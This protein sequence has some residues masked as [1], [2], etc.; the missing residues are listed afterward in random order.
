MVDDGK[1]VNDSPEDVAL[2][3]HVHWSGVSHLA[4][5]VSRS[6]AA[7]ILRD[8]AS[9]LDTQEA[10]QTAELEALLEGEAEEGTA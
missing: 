3:L 2:N 5:K 4:S 7:K 1:H 6:Q 8:I 10:E 9:T